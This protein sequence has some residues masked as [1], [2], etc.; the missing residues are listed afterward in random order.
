M[1][2]GTD[3]GRTSGVAHCIGL[4]VILSLG[5]LL[6]SLARVFGDLNSAAGHVAVL[7]SAID[8]PV[9]KTRLG[10]NIWRSGQP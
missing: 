10:L 8:N 1:T 9:W 2:S 7:E 4:A 3:T 5:L 6:L